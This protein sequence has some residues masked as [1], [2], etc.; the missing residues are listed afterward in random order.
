MGVLFILSLFMMATQ[1]YKHGNNSDS[2]YSFN[3]NFGGS[4]KSIVGNNNMTS[5]SVALNNINSVN[6]NGNFDITV[7]PGKQSNIVLTT[8]EN[9]MP[10]IDITM[11]NDN[12]LSVSIKP[13]VSIKWSRT[14][15]LVI[16]TSN[17]NSINLHGD[18]SVQ[19]A[20]I[21]TDQLALNVAGDSNVVLSGHANNLTITGS[22]D[23]SVDA[24]NL[25]AENVTVTSAGDSD[26]SVHPSK[27]LTITAFGESTIRYSGNPTVI[28]N[29]LGNSNIEQV[30]DK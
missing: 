22:G 18:N 21:N 26:I 27:N 3:F 11:N 2:T 14:P 12:Q 6:I 9:I 19:A 7:N 17:L 5:K 25:I 8:D 24:D 1:N 10:Y 30:D 20:D 28:K 23:S 4:N 15:K 13:G 16:T 29:T